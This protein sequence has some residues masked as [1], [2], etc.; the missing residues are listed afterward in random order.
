MA[1]ITVFASES[2]YNGQPKN[3][4]AYFIG[5]SSAI[6]RNTPNISQKI[7]LSCMRVTKRLKEEL[8]ITEI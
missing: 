3:T 4:T 8:K 2:Q 6:G 5:F 7:A 1:D